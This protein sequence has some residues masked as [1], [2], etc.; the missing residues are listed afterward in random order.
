MYP[1]NISN[2]GLFFKINYFDEVTNKGI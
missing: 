2:D 1:T